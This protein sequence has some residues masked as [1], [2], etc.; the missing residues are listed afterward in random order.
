[1]AVVYGTSP[2]PEDA[3]AGAPSGTALTV[4]FS[5]SLGPEHGLELLLDA[6]DILDDTDGG[7]GL[8]VVVTG[9]GGDAG[10]IAGRLQRLRRVRVNFKGFLPEAGFAACLRDAHVCLALQNPGGRQA[11]TRM[12]S[13]VFEFFL[14]G[15]ATVMTDVGDFFALPNDTCCKLRDYAAPALADLLAGLTPAGCVETGKRARAYAA[16][17]WAA[18]ASG[19]RIDTLF[20][21]TGR[22][23]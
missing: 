1:V 9:K 13:K 7:A 12:P 4:L 6:L 11:N 2:R 8:R 21:G 5:G 3:P 10:R 20:D 23:T 15:K 18:E 19:R 14:A 22:G 16:A 17:N